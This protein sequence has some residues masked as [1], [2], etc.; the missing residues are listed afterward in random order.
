[1]TNLANQY[2]EIGQ[3][4]NAVALAEESVTIYRMLAETSS[5]TYRPELAQALINLCGVLLQ[6]ARPAEAINAA[7][8]AVR[9]LSGPGEVNLASDD[10]TQLLGVALNNLATATRQA[11]KYEAAS[12]A[13]EQ[14]VAVFRRAV[15]ATPVFLPDLAQALV[16]LGAA[17]AD[18]GAQLDALDHVREAAAIY[19]GLQGDQPARLPGLANALSL[20]VRLLNEIGNHAQSVERPAKPLQSTP[21]SPVPIPSSGHS[22][23]VP[24]SRGRSPPM[25][26]ATKTRRS[27][28][29]T[30]R[31]NRRR[32]R[33]SPRHGCGGTPGAFLSNPSE[34]L[35]G[36]AKRSRQLC[37]LMP[38]PGSDAH[39]RCER[40]F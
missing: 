21:N 16:N 36:L 37:R 12:K 23:S 7:E 25:V 30:A 17:R 33:R 26:S 32:P 4:R 18:L 6:L 39:P 20:Q 29:W 24:S 27:R 38:I 1:M 3:Y 31:R 14:S 2:F 8:E 22:S 35:E 13:A 34:E 40:G 5:E 19:R 28:I 9:L 15:S 10:H 11:G